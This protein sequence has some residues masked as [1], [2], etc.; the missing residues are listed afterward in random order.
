MKKEKRPA[1][2]SSVT[3]R[4]YE[5]FRGA[6]RG[7]KRHLVAGCGRGRR[8]GGLYGLRGLGFLDA[9]Y[10]TIISTTTAGYNEVRDLDA[11]GRL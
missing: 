4:A 10:M 7:P 11:S 9:F 5:P 8:D 2:R 6:A 3:G 1:A